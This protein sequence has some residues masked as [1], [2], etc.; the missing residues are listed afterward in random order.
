MM[1][2]TRGRYAIRAMAELATHGENEFV[3]LKEIAEKQNI[4]KKYLE[5]IMLILVKHDLVDGAS[6]KNGG[7]HLK[8]KPQ[9]ISLGE[10]LRV[11][12][13]GLEPVVCIAS[14]SEPCERIEV[15]RTYPIWKGLYDVINEYLDGKTLAD[16]M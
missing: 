6:G 5:S 15:C 13:G 7:Y 8:K 3:P 1:I 12:E 16:V 11:T 10:I 14:E 4:S 9:E 2:S